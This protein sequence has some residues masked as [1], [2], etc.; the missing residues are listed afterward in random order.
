MQPA[1]ISAFAVPDTFANVNPAPIAR[2]TNVAVRALVR[3]TGAI[4]VFVGFAQQDVA[5]PDGPGASA[6]RIVPGASEVFVL[7]PSQVMFAVGAG[8]GARVVTAVSPALPLL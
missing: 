2:A 6:F 8:L 5:G 1:T 3:N 4:V 7:A